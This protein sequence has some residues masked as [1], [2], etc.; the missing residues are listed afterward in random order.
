MSA[1]VGGNTHSTSSY[2]K[3]KAVI[4]QVKRALWAVWGQHWRPDTHFATA[5]RNAWT[6]GRSAA[7]LRCAPATNAK[8]HSRSREAKIPLVAQTQTQ[9]GGRRTHGDGRRAEWTGQ[10]RSAEGGGN[11]AEKQPPSSI[12]AERRPSG[13]PISF[14]LL[15]PAF[16]RPQG[17]SF[18]L[19]FCSDRGRADGDRDKRWCDLVGHTPPPRAGRERERERATEGGRAAAPVSRPPAM[20]LPAPPV[21][22]AL[23]LL[24]ALPFCAAHPGPG[25]FNAPRHFQTPALHSGSCSPTS[26]VSCSHIT[27]CFFF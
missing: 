19:I 1:A 8:S 20:A 25:A 15:P 16:F 3:G 13:L 24:V 12:F 4:W 9:R 7:P 26:R 18:L 11:K 14:V 27:L 22:L 10:D 2:S 21:R 5:T 23:L 6:P 17:F